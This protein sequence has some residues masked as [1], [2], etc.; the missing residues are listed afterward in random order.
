MPKE[1]QQYQL[2]PLPWFGWVGLKLGQGEPVLG[3]K[4]CGNVSLV[5]NDYFGVIRKVSI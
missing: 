3:D 2:F 1:Q 5:V 4:D